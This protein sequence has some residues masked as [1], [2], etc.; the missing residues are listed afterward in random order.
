MASIREL[1]S[2]W[3]SP[4]SDRRRGADPAVR[5]NDD[6]PVTLFRR[7]AK[8]AF[9]IIAAIMGLITLSPIFLLVSIAIKMDS[10]GPVFHRQVGH[11]YNGEEILVVKFRSSEITRRARNSS[12]MT[13]VG[14]VLRRSGLEGLPQLVNVLAGDMSIVGPEM[15]LSVPK[16]ILTDQTPLI[17]RQP[18][19]KP[20]LIGWAQVNGCWGDSNTR[21]AMQRRIKY[22]VYYIE[23]WSFL[24]DMRIIVMALFS[25][26]AYTITE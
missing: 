23:N 8:R 22:D 3:N 26:E 6:G 13:R 5:T 20:G 11:D 7:T 10:R 15:F 4:G 25:K 18:T 21:D 16:T 24:L 1:F 12:P 14:R 19:M 2:Y 17:S 9:D